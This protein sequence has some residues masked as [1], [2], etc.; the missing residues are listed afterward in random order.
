MADDLIAAA[1]AVLEANDRGGYT[2]PSARLYPHQ[3]NWDS[4]FSAIGWRHFDPRRAARELEM[5]VRGQWADGLVPH[6]NF[7]PDAENYEPGPGTW[8][9]SGA[10]GAPSA[11]KTSS[12]T[13]P[14]IAATA[15][16]KVLESAAGDRDTTDALARVVPALDRWHAWFATTRDPRRRGVPCILHP[17]ESGMDNA[18]RWDAA[19]RRI[20]PGEV[21]YKRKDDQ[22]V[23]ASQRP[24]KFEY[25]R[26]FFLVEERARRKFAPPAAEGEPF[27]VEDVA[28]AAILCRAEED[29]AVLADRLGQKDVAGRARARHEALAR[30]MVERL[31]DASAATF[32]DYD[33]VGDARVE[34]E[35]VAH[36]VPLFAG[37]CPRPAIDRILA[38]L[39]DA[40]GF[41][42]PWPIPS[43]PRGASTFDGRRYWRGP[44]WVNVNWMT[45]DGLR[46]A[47][48]RD[49]A[50]ALARRTVELVT[51]SGFGEY[52]DPVTG[53]ALGA[54]SEFGWTA[55]LVI[56]LLRAPAG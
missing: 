48:E 26:Y 23:D 43:V 32:F 15:A 22:V 50:D 20:E 46:R 29:L 37:V 45:I 4:A 27:L 52:F 3:W 17:W 25:D 41:G 35:H 51:K 9:T 14:P 36:L 21:A 11:V 5:L 1:R 53:E 7:H 56:D 19:L 28:M 8:K 31:Y 24:T 6:I 40:D 44:A 2:V 49:A 39:R 54:A 13:Q 16:L 12:I 55:A 42:T 10:P 18:P 30:A 47:G 38:R 33:L 34:G